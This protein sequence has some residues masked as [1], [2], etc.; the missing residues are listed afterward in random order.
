MFL[1]L[2]IL[3]INFWKRFH[4]NIKISWSIKLKY[5][6]VFSVFYILYRKKYLFTNV[7]SI[8]LSLKWKMFKNN[9]IISAWCADSR[10]SHLNLYQT[11]CFRYPLLYR[12]CCS[13][14]FWVLITNCP[15]KVFK[16]IYCEDICL[17]L[18]RFLIW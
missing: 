1:V 12:I 15:G 16:N 6:N 3:F 11:D 4:F 14:R 10:P 2:R 7:L 8:F 18:L 13:S 9:C 5:T 17:I